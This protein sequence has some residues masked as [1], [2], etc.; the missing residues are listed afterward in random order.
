[1]AGYKFH[2]KFGTG[3]AGNRAGGQKFETFSERSER[4]KAERE[5]VEKVRRLQKPEN[6]K[7]EPQ[8][9]SEIQF[10]LQSERRLIQLKLAVRPET[11]T[12]QIVYVSALR[13]FEKT[14]SEL[15]ERKGDPTAKRKLADALGELITF[16]PENKL[17][18]Q[19]KLSKVLASLIS[20]ISNELRHGQTEQYHRTKWATRSEQEKMPKQDPKIARLQ[21]E[22]AELTVKKQRLDAELG[23]K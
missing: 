17:R 14:A 12:A 1:M 11:P 8:A 4:L 7:K 22:L 20:N 2:K 13:K 18:H 16:E 15:V 23:K 6:P 10:L 5:R 21:Q 9:S 3:G 19:Q